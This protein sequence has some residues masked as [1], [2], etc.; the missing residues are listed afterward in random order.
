M[1]G[2]VS[3][4]GDTAREREL[5]RSCWQGSSASGER[6]LWQSVGRLG[7]GAA[8][9]SLRTASRARLPLQSRE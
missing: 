5:V 8:Q 3:L 7:Q 2:L 1:D 4:F 6:V 9:S